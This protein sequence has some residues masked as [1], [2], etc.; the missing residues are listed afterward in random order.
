[1]KK[2]L[3]IFGIS[4]LIILALLIALPLAFQSQ[5]QHLVKQ[6]INDNLNAKVEFSNVNLSFIKNF[7]KAH[8]G[9]DD[10]MITNFEPFKDEKFI[11][12]KNI[13]FS[14]SLKEL[15]KS[16]SDGPLAIN[17]FTID[18][19]EITLKTDSLGR[20]NYDIAKSS[21]TSE[22][23]ESEQSGGF[24]FDIENYGISNSTFI[25]IDD[26]SKTE[27][28][29]SELNHTGNGSFSA[30]TSILDTKTSANVSVSIDN[31]EYLKNNSIKLD[32]LIELDL[33]NN[34]YSFKENTG[35]IN[36]LPLKFD[37]YIRLF[38]D[39]QEVDITFENP[40]SNFKNFLALIP[41]VYSKS[42]EGV[43]TTGDF[44]VK[45]LIKGKITE[46]TIP[47]FDIQITS[48]KASFKY[49]D[50][51][52]RVDNIVINTSIKNSTGLADD[53]HI[54]LNTLNFKIDQ[55]VFK[56]SASISNI[57]SNMFVKAH[58]D[59]VLNLANLKQAY[60]IELDQELS[61][62]LKAKLSTAFDMNAIETS[63]YARIK[64]NGS[65]SVSN[66]VFASKD[67]VNPIHITNAEIS[68]NPQTVSLNS[69]EAKS[70]DSDINANGTI[71]NLIGFLVSNNTLQGNF[72]LK[73]TL[74]KVS[75]FMVDNNETEETETQKES[76]ETSESL[77]IPAFLDCTINAQ[78]NQVV[79]DNLN[80]KD[81]K[82]TLIIKDQQVSLTNL[83]SHIFNGAL[84]VAGNVSTKNNT[85]NFNLNLDINGFDVAQSF[86]GL[87][88]LQ[89]LAPIANLIQG[90]LNSTLNLSGDLTK[91]F[92]PNLSSMSGNALAE[93]L[94][95]SI[96]PDQSA[97]LSKLDNTFNFIDFKKLNLKDIKTKFEFAEG[98]VNVKP[99]QIKYEDITID[100]SGSHG[101]DETM[102]YNAVFNVPAKYL[103]SDIN[104]LIAKI[105]SEEAK[106]I[107]IPVTANIT[108]SFNNPNVKTDLSSG[109]SN[110]SKQLV[111][112]QKQKLLNQGKSQAED[113]LG[114]LIKGNN[115][116][117]DSTREE[118]N[119]NTKNV[120]TD[121]LGNNQNQTDSTKTDATTNTVKNALGGLL[122]KKKKTQ[123]TIK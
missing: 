75:D 104:Q 106:N 110:L 85:P 36:K 7:P 77:K 98:K 51:P 108:G 82:G 27:M 84:A 44:K 54:D 117:T 118:Q 70:G 99:F 88:L 15:F 31:T 111:E 4:I 73:S 29:I 83:T 39:G 1:M 5:I 22:P 33:E 28:R 89:N 21:N 95:T 102:D 115:T 114:N 19:A 122:G 79:Y 87:E 67:V 119:K 86:K 49:P 53:T 25:Y 74:F 35:F 105:D 41:E 69:F 50:L 55:D 103:G 13:A 26:G 107:S 3:K 71:N 37:G 101:F 43:E 9:I 46:T 81:V 60:P 52:K 32:A 45:G 96:S 24:S 30:D 57:T 56:S 92:T 63:N 12:V 40:E 94:T 100:V 16:E 116:K 48:N 47:T 123:D 8:V 11:S 97:A 113:L 80:L 18:E 109:V 14:M 58:I 78:A 62:I 120:I 20:V 2:A 93:L 38:D 64:N 90:T 72:N 10:L 112:I 17:T 76:T 66:F 61:G 91:D 68:F 23:E 65:A 42:I 34:K 6:F 121:I 59:G